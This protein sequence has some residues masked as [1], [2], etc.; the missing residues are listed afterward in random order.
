MSKSTVITL[1]RE[2]GPSSVVLT[3]VLV[4]GIIY[5]REIVT[6]FGGDSDAVFGLHTFVKQSPAEVWIEADITRVMFPRDDRSQC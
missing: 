6:W 4:M 2:W 1:I 3:A 5:H